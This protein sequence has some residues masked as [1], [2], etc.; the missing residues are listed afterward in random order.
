MMAR[1]DEA[2][3]DFETLVVGPVVA[4]K[5]NAAEPLRF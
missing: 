2:D 5:R 3:A 4:S 1:T